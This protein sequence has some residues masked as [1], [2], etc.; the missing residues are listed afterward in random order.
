MIDFSNVSRGSKARGAGRLSCAILFATLLLAGH[1]S[2]RAR[3]LRVLTYNIHHSEGNDAV[4][5]LPR[6]ANVIAATNPDLVAL[7]ELDQGNTRSGVNVFQLDQ[8][9]QLTGMQ[10]FFG[11]TIDYRG[12]AYG[13]GVLV[14][15]DLHVTGVANHALPS[16]AGGEARRVM[17][18]GVSLDGANAAPE[19]EFFA[20]HFTNGSTA[21]AIRLSQ[22]TFV[23]SLITSSAVPALVG[24]DF[25]SNPGT[26]PW[27]R[28]RE[29]WEDPTTAAPAY[30]RAAQIDNVFY[31]SSGQW[32]VIEAGN[33]IVNPTTQVASDHY[34]YLVSVELVPE[35]AGAVVMIGLLAG[36]ARRRR[37]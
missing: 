25:N 24:G 36:L 22:A 28:L 9:A 21:G 34:P 27:Q 31:R 30:P 37:S 7:Q 33:F 12:G 20:T 14:R 5:N 3:T 19:F 13:N 23:N 16:P 11:K 10:G 18:L 15:N 29:Q 4:Y 26:P 35:P 1:G 8:L 2:A 6:I 32:N 17:Q